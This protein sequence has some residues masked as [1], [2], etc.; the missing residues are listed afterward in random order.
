LRTAA[1]ADIEHY[2]V[3]KSLENQKVNLPTLQENRGSFIDSIIFIDKYNLNY[4]H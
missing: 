2:D 3:H 4:I 1:A